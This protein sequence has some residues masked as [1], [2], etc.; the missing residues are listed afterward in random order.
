VWWRAVGFNPW[1]AVAYG[2]GTALVVDEFPLLLNLRDV[3]WSTRGRGSVDLALATIAVATVC[4]AA[5]IL[6]AASRA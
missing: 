3:Y 4:F 2:I 5:K 1:L 6:L